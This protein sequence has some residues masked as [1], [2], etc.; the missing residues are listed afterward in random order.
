MLL[1]HHV[2]AHHSSIII[3]NH[4]TILTFTDRTD[5]T[6]RYAHRIVGVAE[7]E[8]ELL[9]LIVGYY[10]LI[11]NGTPKI[12]MTVDKDNAWDGFNTHPC[13]VLLHVA[14]K[15]FSLWMVHTVTRSSLNQQVA[16]ECLLNAVD[17]AVAQ[18]TAIL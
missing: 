16:I 17:V 18:R 7:F 15:G 8:K 14:L 10:S 1:V 13:E 5:N 12:L 2:T 11:G 3:D 6:L 4:G 9:L